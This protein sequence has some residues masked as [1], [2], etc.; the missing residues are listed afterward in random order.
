LMPAFDGSMPY[1]VF[2]G[3]AV[4]GAPQPTL[5]YHVPGQGTCIAIAEDDQL[6]HWKPL[7]ENPVISDRNTS[8][9]VTVFDPC[10]WKDRAFYYALIGNKSGAPGHEGD[11]ASLFRSTDLIHWDYRGPFYKSDRRW[12]GE[13]EDCACPDFFPLGDKHMLLMHT[14]LPY[15]H[16]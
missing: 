6:N 12:T 15:G 13:D 14:H 3:D 9:E 2:S 4:E 11:C 5:I 10:A 1:G 7:T 16:C 8:P